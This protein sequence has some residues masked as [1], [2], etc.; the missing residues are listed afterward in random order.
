M[1]EREYDR[2]KKNNKKKKERDLMK[3]KRNV[4]DELA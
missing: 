2:F 4:N 1:R 3:K